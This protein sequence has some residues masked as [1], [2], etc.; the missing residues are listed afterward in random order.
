MHEVY[1]QL[2]CADSIA[3]RGRG[4]GRWDLSLLSK[5]LTPTLTLHGRRSLLDI[6]SHS[7]SGSE[8]LAYHTACLFFENAVQVALLV[9]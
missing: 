9:L 4:R 1:H 6:Y 5:V 8:M 7:R 3:R 2:K